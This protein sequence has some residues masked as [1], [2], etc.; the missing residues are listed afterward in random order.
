M[1]LWAGALAM[2]CILGVP[3]AFLLCR[4][5]PS[6]GV[7]LAAPVGLF[8]A[9]YLAWLG[10][11]TGLFPNGRGYA[12]AALLVFAGLSAALA[13]GLRAS[14]GELRANGRLWLAGGFLLLAM[15]ALGVGLRWLNPEIGGTEKPMDF[16]LLNAAAR[17][18]TLP[19][20]DPWFAGETINYYYLGYSMAAFSMHL[21][22]TEPAAG[23]NLALAA[24]FGLGAVAAA[25]AG[26]DL[27]TLTGAGRRARKV[28]AGLALGLTM[29]AGNLAVV[30]DIFADSADA[31]GD[32]W[33]G[34][35]WNASR[36]IQRED[37]GQ[38]IDYTINEFPAFSFI[39]GD[40]HPHVMALPITLVAVSLAVQWV[41]AAS[42]PKLDSLVERLARGGL[43]G[44]VLGGLYA[45]NAWDA[46]TFAGLVLA[47]GVVVAWRDR[48]RLLALAPATA[49]ALIV[50]VVAWLPYTLNYAPGSRGIGVVTVRSEA[51]DHIQVFGLLVGAAV[52]ALAVLL[53]DMGPDGRL[54]LVALLV[55]GVGATLIARGEVVVALA[56]LLVLSVYALG[57][58]RSEPGLAALLWLL[59]AGLGLLT[60]VEAL[61][62][63]DFF[64]PPNERMNTVFKLHYQA[65]SLLAV[66]AGPG[67]VLT[68]RRLAQPGGRRVQWAR[69]VAVSAFVL[70]AVPALAYPIVATRAKTEASPVSGSLDGLAAAR[71]NRPSEVA[72]AEWLRRQAPDDAVLLEAPGRAY[73]GDSR[74]ATWTGIPSVIGWTQHEE[75]WRESDPRIAVRSA[76]IDS[77]YLTDD[78]ALRR[79]V[80]ERYGVTHVV[81]GDSE[82]DR[83]GAEVVDRLRR[84]LAVAYDNGG[85][86]IFRVGAVR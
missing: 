43:T 10:L 58:F 50:A 51:L 5:L 53:W 64:G 3:W 65:W 40:L 82:R 12:A 19:P 11:S 41:V 60:V 33:R 35:G 4:G 66:A 23:Y 28:A 1:L 52:V 48:A 7:L 27:A 39:L 13:W 37:G 73:S 59:V 61:Y 76:D 77:A 2:L 62:V 14:L 34:V 68:W 31:P 80:L 84:D 22:G 85:T 75:L 79:A 25:S 38:V 24:L 16:A 32:F 69:T 49:A 45:L 55:A 44:L 20:P 67:L 18:S 70:L 78:A 15:F 47:G 56:A 57:L 71:L 17:G 30:R 46:P 26:Y 81:A 63:D 42:Q 74:M 54:L 29:L 8:L 9:H 6:R 36:T 86:T 83:Y 72:A 21:S